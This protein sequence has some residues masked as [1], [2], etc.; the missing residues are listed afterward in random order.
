MEV[1]AGIER[2]TE[3]GDELSIRYF[4]IISSFES[5]IYFLDFQRI[6]TLLNDRVFSFWD[7]VGFMLSKNH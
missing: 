2:T 1:N 7:Q 3:T 4:S 6:K 5:E